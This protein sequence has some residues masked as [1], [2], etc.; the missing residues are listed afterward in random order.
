MVHVLAL[1]SAIIVFV[2]HFS[3]SSKEKESFLLELRQE[4]DVDEETV[5]TLRWEGLTSASS[6]LALTT[7]GLMRLHLPEQQTTVLARVMEDVRMKQR[8]Q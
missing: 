8:I 4:Y 3:E 7:D 2:L 1:K 6:L 5:D